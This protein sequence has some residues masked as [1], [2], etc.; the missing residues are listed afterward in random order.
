MTKK[1][2]HIVVT[3]PEFLYILLTSE[4]G[5]RMLSTTRTLI[6]DEIHAIVDDKRG[7]HLSLSIERLQALV[8]EPLVRIGLSATQKP[9][10]EVARFL[11]GAGNLESDGKPKCNIVDTGHTRR[12]DLAIVKIDAKKKL[13]PLPLGDSSK[14]PQGLAI[15]RALV[16]QGLCSLRDH[17]IHDYRD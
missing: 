11:V 17:C 4:G 8:K 14:L 6:V 5:R 3:T 12:L 10:E 2:P 1:P 9:I 13:K 7:S 15:V 16:D